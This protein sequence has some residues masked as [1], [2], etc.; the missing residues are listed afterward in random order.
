MIAGTGVCSKL[1]NKFHEL[2]RVFQPF[3]NGRYIIYR[4]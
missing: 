2:F 4:L 3:T 1:A